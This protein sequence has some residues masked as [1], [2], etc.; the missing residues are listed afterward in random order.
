[1]TN[2]VYIAMYLWN[3]SDSLTNRKQVINIDCQRLHIRAIR[4]VPGS[5]AQFVKLQL[6]LLEGANLKWS[7]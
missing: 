3:A 1:M 4:S 2:C 5:Y 6:L 7:I